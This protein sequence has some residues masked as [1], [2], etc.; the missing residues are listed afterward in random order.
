[1]AHKISDRVDTAVIA[2]AHPLL[3][4][5]VLQLSNG[6]KY[7]VEAVSAFCAI[8]HNGS[9]SGAIVKRHGGTWPPRGHVPSRPKPNGPE[10]AHKLSGPFSCA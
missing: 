1:M 6:D 10:A 7:R 4:C 3:A 5:T 9:A 8:V 2:D